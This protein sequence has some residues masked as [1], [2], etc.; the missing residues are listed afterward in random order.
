LL[1]IM[2]KPPEQPAITLTG[3]TIRAHIE[4]DIIRL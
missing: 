3:R 4:T 1:I 2:L